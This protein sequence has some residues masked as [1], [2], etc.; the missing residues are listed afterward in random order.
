MLNNFNRLTFDFFCI[1]KDCK[2]I[3]ICLAGL[4][5]RLS[6]RRICKYLL[7]AGFLFP[8][9]YSAGA[10]EI[11][12]IENK[13]SATA[14]GTDRIM[15]YNKMVRD[16]LAGG[17]SD[18]AK[19]L[20]YAER[21]LNLAE[22]EKYTEGEAELNETVGAVYFSMK[23][24]NKSI[25]Y[26]ETALQICLKLNDTG[27][28]ATNYYNMGLCFDKLHKMYDALDCYL[29]ALSLKKQLNDSKEI[30]PI[31][32]SVLNAY[33][34]LDNLSDA[35][36]YTAEALSVAKKTGNK[37]DEASL[38]ALYADIC[39]SQEKH[40][41]AEKYY[42]QSIRLYSETVDHLHVAG[43][44][45]C[46]ASLYDKSDEKKSIGYRIRAAGIYEKL[47]PGNSV[48]AKIYSGIG[49]IYWERQMM[50]SAAFYYQKSVEK[51][52]VSEDQQVIA[53]TYCSAGKFYFAD[54]N[55]AEAMSMF[56]KA[57]ALAASMQ[58]EDILSDALFQLSCVYAGTGDYRK[59][60]ETIRRQKTV[61]DS[62]TV[63]ESGDKLL[64]LKRQHE[65]EKI[66]QEKEIALRLEQQQSAERDRARHISAL[67]AL[68]FLLILFVLTVRNYRK[69]KK[70]GK[71]REEQTSEILKMN[72][73]LQESHAELSMYKNH[74]EDMVRQQTAK[75]RR[76]QKQLYT[77]S[78]NLS[79]GCIYR[80]Y[81]FPDQTDIISYI[82]NTSYKWLGVSAEDIMNDI[83]K[84][85]RQIVPEDLERKLN[86]EKECAQQMTPYTCEYRLYKNGEEVW[87]LENA[88]PYRSKNRAF[89]WDGVIV[90]ITERKNHEK[91]V[92]RAK[93]KAEESDVLKS[94]FLA[95]MSHEI[96][97]PMNGI[98]GFLSFLERENLPEQKRQTYI[99]IIRDNIHQ[100]LQLIG[101][102]L[103]ISKIDSNQM[104]IQSATVDINRLMEELEIFYH[105]LIGHDRK[106]LELVLDKGE[107]AASC[108]IETD[109]TR[110]RQILINLL[111][112]AVKFTHIGYIRFGYKLLNESSEILF[113]VED[114]GIG[115]AKDSQKFVFDRFRQVYHS[116]QLSE[117][118]GTGLG[119]SISANLIKLMGGHIWL[120]SEEGQGTVF[121]FT[122]PAGCHSGQAEVVR[123]NHSVKALN[124]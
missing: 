66:R 2:G 41:E 94:T 109:P 99:N 19:A 117:Y 90:D 22:A 18:Y 14:P 88:Q 79:N 68:G 121:F 124:I 37:K 34:V 84:L 31:Y 69:N 52:L 96:R 8:Y 56:K 7:V 16:W 63:K 39:F 24:Y 50:D 12:S 75:L 54:N 118:R 104:S 86:L 83:D 44:M 71:L 73:Q 32:K 30:I 115:I 43:V 113:Y 105:D 108:T 106:K 61:N 85:Y 45:H 21:A 72:M 92:I 82:S 103:D 53:E 97:T 36:E 51:A 78:D 17:D 77:L 35:V 59:A 116:S 93:E 64:Q 9:G 58:Y 76:N 48:M 3:F 27:G 87:L 114:T 119:L 62:L 47:D 100:L 13:L 49:S 26:Y 120:E 95:N 6:Y 57:E 122:L 98:I 1:P 107:F 111:N 23:D 11:D 5:Q 70:A 80:K 102:I 15:F 46:M 10:K 29:K 38:F 74:L 4:T 55:P 25:S 123:N 40:Q 101:D 91:E 42:N 28:C 112:N 81:S 20:Y 89:V 67:I 60:F 33:I 65:Y 110:L